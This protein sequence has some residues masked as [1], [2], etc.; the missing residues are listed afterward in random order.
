M[1]N[2]AIINNGAKGSTGRIAINLHNTLLSQG[3]SSKFCYGRGILSDNDT[4]YLIQSSF[5]LKA[6]AFRSR[7][8]GCQG[9]Y[10]KKPTRK[11][12]NMFDIWDIDTIFIV[13]IHGY[14]I[15]EELL[16]KYVS[17]KN[18]SLVHT[19]IDEYAFTGKCAYTNGCKRYKIGCGNCPHKSEYPASYL[20]DGSKKVYNMKQKAYASLNHSLFVGPEFVVNQAKQSP[21]FKHIR[22]EILDE[23][24]DTSIYFPRDCSNLK[25]KLGID[26]S[27]L[28]I[29]CVAPYNGEASDRKGVRYFIELAKTFEYNERFVFVQVGFL[30]EDKSYLPSNYIPI[31]FLED[32]DLL[33]Y[34]F[35]LG[36]L[37]VFPSLQDTMPN[38]CLDSLACGTPILCF[39]ISGMPYLADT[40]IGQYVTP[41][42]V[43]ELHEVVSHT[44]KKDINTISKCRD[45]AMKRYDSTVYNNKL[46]NFAKQL[47]IL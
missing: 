30:D 5:D 22:T 32:E 35:S 18:I 3:Y 41:R 14:Y 42:N 33:A 17:Y 15:C 13:S 24:I 31:G 2:V 9:F 19:M 10:S 44:S 38:A 25:K 43:N 6:H 45:Y 4:W 1:K 28:I 21:L 39:N 34:Y 23:A 46:I 26:E 16:Y 36:D 7:L 47:N 8:T 29:T 40:P 12:L 11:L 37:F 27:K 20:L